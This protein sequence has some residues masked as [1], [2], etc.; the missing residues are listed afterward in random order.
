MEDR[1]DSAAPARTASS[2][3]GGGGK[4]PWRDTGG[5]GAFGDE[6]WAPMG[7]SGGKSD[8]FFRG[9]RLLVLPEGAPARRAS[10]GLGTV[11]DFLARAAEGGAALSMPSQT[12]ICN[13]KSAWFSARCERASAAASGL[14]RASGCMLAPR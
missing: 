6:D 11:K 4:G 7:G 5:E 1:E 2:R 8:A 9:P 3:S 13:G 10:E 14:A 12:P